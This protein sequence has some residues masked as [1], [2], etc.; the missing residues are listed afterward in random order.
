MLSIAKL[1]LRDIY[2]LTFEKP[3]FLK[4]EKTR[5][6]LNSMPQEK[7]FK[8]YPTELFMDDPEQGIP[9]WEISWE[10]YDPKDFWEYARGW[11]WLR[12]YFHKRDPKIV[13][14]ICNWLKS[15]PMPYGLTWAVNLEVAIRALNILWLYLLTSDEDLKRIL[16]DHNAYIKKRL[17]YSKLF[18]RNNH[19]LGELITSAI[20]EKILFSRCSSCNKV[21]P[22]IYKQYNNDGTNFEGS[23]RYH[24]F[25]T[26]FILLFN[27]FFPEYKLDKL[28][29]KTM[30]FV[31][32]ITPPDKN[33]PDI[34]D[35]DDG[36]VIRLHDGEPSNDDFLSLLSIGSVLYKSPEY[37]FI[38]ERLYPEALLLYPEACK[39]W[40][41]IKAIEPPSKDIVFSDGGYLISRS[42]WEKGANYFLIKF[43]SVK[44]HSHADIFHIVLYWNGIPILVDSGTYRYNNEPKK[45]KFFRSTAA[46]NTA[47][48]NDKD[49]AIQVGTFRW[50][51]KASARNL[52][53]K[54]NDKMVE[55]EGWHDGYMRLG[56]VHKRKV[57]LH[58]DNWELRVVDYIKSISKKDVKIYWHFHPSIALKQMSNNQFGIYHKKKDM[59]GI[60]IINSK[61]GIKVNKLRTHYSKRYGEIGEKETIEIAIRGRNVSVE[62]HFIKKKEA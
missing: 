28:I 23:I 16:Y 8:S 17:S 37:K 6:Q 14:E 60:L 2:T 36:C 41:S 62:S 15:N 56:A 22:E 42:S 47:V 33:Y 39:Y 1:L 51:T 18:I 44:W 48:I 11:K 21:I 58:K 10:G 40:Y 9:F 27:Y 12:L 34:G 53:C 4:R 20:L 54:I 52:K 43:G 26:Q 61:N 30:D 31:M 7:G 13:L 35:N 55:F 46:H 24:L 29:K 25:S 45:R 32:Y 50:L 38:S 19:Y 3:Y 5:S 59:L 57:V 49:Q